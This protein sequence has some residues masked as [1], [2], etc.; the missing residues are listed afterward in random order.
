MKPPPDG[1]P[2]DLIEALR[3]GPMEALR[4]LRAVVAQ[5]QNPGAAGAGAGAGTVQGAGPTPQASAKPAAATTS[6]TG[7][8]A[9]A[10]APAARTGFDEFHD[11]AATGFAT[12]SAAAGLSTAGL[13]AAVIDALQRGKRIE[14]IRRLR[15]ASGLGLAEARALIEHHLAEGSALRSP[16]DGRSPGEVPRSSEAVWL[17]VI[18]LLLAWGLW[19]LWQG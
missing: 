9:S 4:R 18:A 14:A 16:L 13:P 17:L 7:R 5:L 12:P 1:L 3:G 2:D 19:Q 10:R 8:E 11:A 6:S 15:E